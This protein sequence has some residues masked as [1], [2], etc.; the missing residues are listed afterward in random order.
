MTGKWRGT[1]ILGPEYESDEGKSFEFI[2]DLLDENRT[3]NG[4]CYEAGL[5]EL[6]QKP[7]TVTGFWENGLIS[8]TKKYPCLYFLG[9]DGKVVIDIMNEQPDIFYSGE[10]DETENEFSGDFEMVVDSISHGEGWLESSLTGTW[11]LKRI[12]E[13]LYE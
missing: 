1:Y 10:L 6:F 3:F 5:S 4:V 13:S 2:L 12:E 8:F 7:I 11:T 9:E